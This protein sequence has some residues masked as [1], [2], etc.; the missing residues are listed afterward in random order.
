MHSFIWK[1]CKPL[2]SC[3]ECE[4]LSPGFRT[5]TRNSAIWTKLVIASGLFLLLGLLACWL[6][7]ASDTIAAPVLL[8]TLSNLLF[9]T[10]VY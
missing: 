9:L 5:H 8:H 4:Y 3:K 7:A 10:S 2:V 6:Y 1:V